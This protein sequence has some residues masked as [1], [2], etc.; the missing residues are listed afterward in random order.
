MSRRNDVHDDKEHV[1]NYIKWEEPFWR[2]LRGTEI[3]KLVTVI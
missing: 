1:V 2:Y 3:K